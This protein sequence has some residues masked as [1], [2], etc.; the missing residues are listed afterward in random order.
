MAS[1]RTVQMLV[2]ALVVVASGSQSARAEVTAEDKE[3]ARRLLKQGKLHLVARQFQEALGQFQEAYRRW[4]RHEI[5]FNIALVHLELGN[6]LAAAT[7]LRRYLKRAGPAAREIL[8]PPL[9]ALLAQ[10][11]VIQLTEADI[12]YSVWVDGKQVGVGQAEVVVLPGQH[13]LEARV[14][15]RV[16]ARETVT[17]VGGQEMRWQPKISSGGLGDGGGTNGG[18][19]RSQGARR[20]HWAY[21]V[22]F[23]ALA[24]ISGATIIGTGLEAVTLNDEYQETGDEEV[25]RRGK[26]YQLATNV[27]VGLAGATAITAAMLAV[28]TRWRAEKPSPNALRFT[29]TVGPGGLSM[30]LTGRF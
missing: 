21:F 23:G 8:V 10:V 5:Q 2:L 9:K 27:L 25:M 28:F 24:V 12:R 7:S 6:R 22:T 17:L 11:A 29:P 26:R 30:Q 18:S 20:L 16:L 3:T 14:A 15:D 19:D 4:P 13:F 1:M